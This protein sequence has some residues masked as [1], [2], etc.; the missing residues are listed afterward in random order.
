[1]KRRSRTP[2]QRT[3]LLRHEKRLS[4]SG[5]RLIAGVDEAGRGPL[6]GPV[7]AGAVILKGLDFKSRIDDSKKLSAKAR[8]K[9]YK[10]ISEKAI[11]GVG[12]VDERA[13][14]KINIYRATIKA[15]QSAISNLEVDPDYV[16]V[17]GRVKLSVKYPVKCIIRG[18]QASLSIAAAS[19]IAKVTRDA[20]MLQYDR[21]YPQYGFARHKGYPTKF[22]KSALKE[23]GPSPIHRRSYK[24]VRDLLG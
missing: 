17:D 15:M 1:L 21:L 4:R 24:P 5:Y 19:I 11:I 23:H 8:E 20:I 6:A 14:D 10:E 18:D 7:V 12:I 2:T 13:I 3:G 9:A 16:I 22:H